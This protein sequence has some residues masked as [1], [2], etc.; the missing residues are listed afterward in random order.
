MVARWPL[1]GIRTYM[2]YVYRH[3]DRSWRLTILASSTQENESLRADARELGAE[4]VLAEGGQARLCREALRLIGSRRFDLVQSHGFISAVHV[5]LAGLRRRVPHVLTVHGVL[6]DRLLRGLRGRIKRAVTHWAVLRSD[7]VYAVGRDILE[8][9]A[10]EMPSFSGYAGRRA[11]IPNGID[12]DSFRNHAGDR[13][14]FRREV[15]AGEDTF[16][17]G[18]LGRFMPQKGLDLLIEAAAALEAG[19][20]AGR[21]WRMALVG[22]GDYRR[23]YEWTIHQ[24]GL[25]RRFIFAPF[26]SDVAAVYRDLDAVVMPS[27]WEACPLQPMEA[28]VSGVPLVASDCIGLREVI[29]D[30][31]ALVFR[32]GDARGLAAALRRVLDGG[33]AGRF[34]EFRD[35]AAERFDVRRTA[36]RVR[37]LFDEVCAAEAQEGVR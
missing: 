26:R 25:D 13:G 11:V 36:V 24:R 20:G 9:L 2:K 12:V 7:V 35:R 37:E 6:E 14:G 15:G 10:E 19:V 3:L 22:S 21:D 18:F 17:F 31:P 29:E 5:A 34:R 4:L 27:R 28:L 32:N 16:L 23:T 1:G 8:H 33:E 30:T